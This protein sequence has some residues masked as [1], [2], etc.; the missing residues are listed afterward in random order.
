M[1]DFSRV[2]GDSVQLTVE[3]SSDVRTVSW[4]T[5]GVWSVGWGEKNSVFL[6]IFSAQQALFNL[7]GQYL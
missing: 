5:L 3:V 7:C 2:I 1:I 6:E 4:N